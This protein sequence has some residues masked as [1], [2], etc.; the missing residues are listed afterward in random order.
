MNMDLLETVRELVESTAVALGFEIVLLKVE[1]TRRI[2]CTIDRDPGG[3]TIDDCTALS[4]A[5]SSALEKSELDPGSFHV[6]VM[7]PGVNRPLV[8]DKDFVRFGNSAVRVTLRQ[9]RDGRK[10]IQGTLVG[11]RGDAVV[12]RLEPSG[13][14]ASFPRRDVKEVRLVPELG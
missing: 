10:N 11:L 1:K 8:R 3:V 12:I 2:Q 6:E 4:R 14:E 13:Q 7:S 5:I 9:K